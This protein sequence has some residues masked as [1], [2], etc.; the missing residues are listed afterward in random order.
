MLG[1]DGPPLAVEDPAIRLA[2]AQALWLDPRYRLVP[3]FAEAAA[4]RG[5]DCR[6]LD[7]ADPGA[8]AQVNAW[9]AEHTE[10]MIREIVERFHADDVMALGDAAYFEGSWTDAVRARADRARAVHAAGR[11][12]GAHARDAHG[13][14]GRLLRGRRGPGRAPGLRHRR[15]RASSP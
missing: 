5:V 13:R 7:F 1:D 3:A 2:L 12:D 14:G 8:P 4:R 11:V 10:G 6:A 15:A 9:A